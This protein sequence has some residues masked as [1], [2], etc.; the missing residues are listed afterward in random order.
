MNIVRH[1]VPLLALGVSLTACSSPPTPT[2][3]DLTSLGSDPPELS[4]QALTCR[5]PNLYVAER[6]ASTVAAFDAHAT[7][8]VRPLLTL[9]GPHT[10]LSDVWGVAFDATGALYTQN[11]I[12][13]GYLNAF[14][15]GAA[16]DARPLR[17]SRVGP[18][19]RTVAVDAQGYVYVAT[20]QSTQQIRVYSPGS[21]GDPARDFNVVPVRNIELPNPYS[22]GFT[23]SNLSVDSS[24]H[25]LV[26]AQSV[27]G[28]AVLVYQGGASGA[29]Q[30]IRI[31]TGS[32]TRLGATQS[33]Y[34]SPFTL[35]FSPLT[36]RLYTAVSDGASTHI[37]VFQGDASGNVAPLRT[38]AGP[39]TGLAGLVVTGLADDP[40]QGSIYALSAD[41]VFGKSGQVLVFGRLA[42]GNVA[43][44]RRFTE[45][46][47]HL[48]D[49]LG[50]AFAP[51][52][53]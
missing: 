6:G 26:A 23:P 13:N 42:Q 36:G 30:P 15:P 33:A 31:L 10:Q 43:P 44:L 41:S 32:S 16:G 46:N 4:A 28:N 53:P 14:A 24:G 3:A 37:N 51:L 17:T 40:C 7:G 39:A 47:T 52:T 5:L 29:A 11:F 12:G 9:H 25:L 20:S 27:Q 48:A 50:M 22:L 38:I 35:T 49:S 18:D 1:V 19:A 2:K 45:I 8:E 21:Q 34:G